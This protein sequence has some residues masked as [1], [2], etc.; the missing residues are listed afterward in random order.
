MRTTILILSIFATL[1]CS[2][3]ENNKPVI[4]GNPDAKQLLVPVEPGGFCFAIFSDRTSGDDEI[5]YEVYDKAIEQV[6]MMQPD[7][8]CTIGDLIQGYGGKDDWIKEAQRYNRTIEKL[9]VPI[10]PVA[11]N[12]EIY[13]KKDTAARDSR[14]HERD[15]EEYFG[16]LW[17][18][19]EYKNCWFI[20]LFSDEGD[21]ESGEKGYYKPQLQKFSDEQYQ[22]LK[23]ILQK[24]KN[25]DH[26]FIFQH[27][28]RWDGAGYG[29]SWQRVHKMLVDAG[30]VSAVFA[31]HL[32]TRE[33][34]QKDGIDYYT[35][36]TTGGGISDLCPSCVHQ[37]YWLSV[38]GEDYNIVGVPVDSLNDPHDAVTKTE[39]VIERQ[40]WDLTSA[41][42]VIE[43]EVS[44][45][46]AGTG[47]VQI[48]TM[49]QEAW[50]ESGDSGV[51]AVFLDENKNV[52]FER[53]L[54]HKDEHW[55]SANLEAGKVY[56]VQLKD[57]DAS[58]T[59]DN[60][61][62]QGQIEVQISYYP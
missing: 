23:G 49:I 41:D 53:V 34:S 45:V 62:N 2:F 27:H 13:W 39:T 43:Y 8:V 42:Q 29:D 52:I 28:P 1:Q 9:K 61:G 6:N 17:Y 30:N 7:F 16:P 20:S 47:K 46:H 44:T 12:H 11:G 38:D 33:Y 60:A 22:W 21:K 35:L 24:A 15:F 26:V 57:P 3:A 56:Y 14:H 59:G 4:S 40:D 54:K 36:S 19:F 25:A 55:Y 5:G 31:G 32:H 18:A 50:D 51:T 37:W 48:N 10:Y 58:F